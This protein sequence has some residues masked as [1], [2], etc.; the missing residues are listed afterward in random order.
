MF[1]WPEEETVDGTEQVSYPICSLGLFE[2]FLLVTSCYHLHA[3]TLPSTLEAGM[4]LSLT[5]K[6]L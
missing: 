2:P 1:K 6:A 5:L 4:E 3:V